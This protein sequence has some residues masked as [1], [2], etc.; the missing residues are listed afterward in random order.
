MRTQHVYNVLTLAPILNLTPDSDPN[1]HQPRPKS[2]N[3]GIVDANAF[4]EVLIN[5]DAACIQCSNSVPYC[6]LNPRF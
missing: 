6:V 1:K 2:W 3:C 4:F 5:A